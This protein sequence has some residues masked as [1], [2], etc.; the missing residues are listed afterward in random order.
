[1]GNVDIMNSNDTLPPTTRVVIVG[2][3][4]IDENTSG[5]ESVTTA[6][7]SAMFIQEQ[8]ASSPGLRITILAPYSADFAPFARDARLINPAQPGHTLRYRNFLDGDRRRQECV[9]ADNAEPVA[10]DARA[11]AEIEQADIL[12]LCPLLPNFAPEY[13]AEV[14]SHAPATAVK[15]LLVQ[16]Y[17]RTVCDDFR[18][19]QRDFLEYS[20]VLPLFDIAVFSDEDIDN[21]LP[22]AASWSA[23]F[24]ATQIVVTQNR[25]G[26][27]YF[28]QGRGMPV[29]AAPIPSREPIN[30][31][32][33]GDVFSAALALA[34]FSDRSIHSAVQHAH[35]AAACRW[36]CRMKVPAA[37][38]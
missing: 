13:V 21:A 34:Y 8:L 3:V 2:H 5:T 23:Q 18:I 4:C 24:A 29:P 16:G 36:L 10:L 15:L 1:V 6:G 7:S 25:D 38:A 11:I 33:A 9:G 14:V 37:A 28:S 27:T 22:L 35:A 19:I 30:A 31:I 20:S 32:G 26:A 12:I 17:L